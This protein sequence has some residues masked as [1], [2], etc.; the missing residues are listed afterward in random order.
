MKRIIAAI[1]LVASIGLALVWYLGLADD[2]SLTIGI[3][4]VGLAA[5]LILD[6]PALRGGKARR[7]D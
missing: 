2:R 7:R 6:F 4:V 1:L 3:A 5:M